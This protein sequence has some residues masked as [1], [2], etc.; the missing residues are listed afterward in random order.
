MSDGRTWARATAGIVLAAGLAG[1]CAARQAPPAGR[2]APSPSFAEFDRRARDGGSFRVVC[3]GASL[4]WGANATD[5]ARTSY[6]AVLADLFEA[7]YPKSRFR[8]HDA[9]IGG[10]NSQL[11]VFRLERDVLRQNPDLVFLDFSANDDINSVDPETLASYEAILR[12]L[13][14][15]ARVPVVQVLFPF[16]WNISRAA[17]PKMKRRDAHI[18]LSAAYRTGLGDA[19]ALILDRV[20]AKQETVEGIWDTDGVHPGDRGYTLFAEAAW[21]GYCEAVLAGRVCEAP[22]RPLH[23][24][25]YATA[26]RFRLATLEPLPARWGRGKPKLTACNHD[27]LMSRWLDD[28]ATASNAGP[29]KKAA[30]EPV[31]RLKLT[32]H[33]SALFLF[34]ESTPESGRFRVW[35]DGAPVSGKPSQVKGT[36]L[37]EGN[38]WQ[39][40]NGFL[41]YEIARGLDPKV[42]HRVE[43]EPVFAGEKPQ[44]LRLESLCVAGG[45]ATVESA[46]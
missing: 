16:K 29:D 2:E 25:T 12:R 43:I 38:R 3:F 9:A 28:L 21:K 41:Y 1:G 35:I 39:T 20:E 22:P 40:G 17:L 27:W 11:G 6:R 4:T 23:A 34:G 32:V 8:F 45:P 10:T 30:A 31:P 15:E 42:P 18:A 33:G 36:D 24:D 37:F 46:E 5:P 19:I 44:E 13:V 26:R 7:R 14:G